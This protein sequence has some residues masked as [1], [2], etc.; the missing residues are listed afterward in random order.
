MSIRFKCPNCGKH[1][2]V[3]DELEGK[4]GKC[5]CGVVIQI[6]SKSALQTSAC[7]NG[8][9]AC[10]KAGICARCLRTIQRGEKRELIEGKMYCIDCAKRVVQIQQAPAISDNN[11]FSD[12]DLDIVYFDRDRIIRKNFICRLLGCSIGALITIAFVF[13]KS[14]M[15]A[16]AF[17]GVISVIFVLLMVKKGYELDLKATKDKEAY[18]QHK[19]D[20][21]RRFKTLS[22]KP[23]TKL[24]VAI[25]LLVICISLII[26]WY[27]TKHKEGYEE[28]LVS[29]F[30]TH[31]GLKLILLLANIPVFILIGRLMVGSWKKYWFISK[32]HLVPF[33]R[34]FPFFFKGWWK[35]LETI[36]FED[37]LLVGAVN[38]LCI[39]IYL[40]E[41][42]AIKVFFLS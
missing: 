37:L 34:A 10:D 3:K 41:Y 2:A 13:V 28:L 7:D 5:S 31:I 8:D 32:W 33:A 16:A 11:R 24:A 1:Y 27:A 19:A 35:M 40:L 4:S 39:T 42:L 21:N 38:T 17:V 29:F 22:N 30:T 14:G 6:R 15:M 12:L 23:Q 36:S 18:R 20:Y 25:F 26:R 9:Q